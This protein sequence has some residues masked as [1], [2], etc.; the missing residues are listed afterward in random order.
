MFLRY[1]GRRTT[2]LIAVGK[3]L[4]VLAL[5]R[6]KRFCEYY[7]A[8]GL[9]ETEKCMWKVSILESWIENRLWNHADMNER[10]L[11]WLETS[12]RMAFFRPEVAFRIKMFQFDGLAIIF[13]FFI[14]SFSHFLIFHITEYIIRSHEVKPEGYEEAHDGKCITVFSAPNYWLVV[15]IARSKKIKKR[16]STCLAASD[17]TRK[18]PCRLPSCADSCSSFP[19][20]FFF[21]HVFSVLP[22]L[23]LSC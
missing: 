5:P 2:L 3:S 22:A 18:I 1:L 19:F 11:T 13:F 20:T 7:W 12:V 23:F 6:S 15:C 8:T 4:S 16:K 17:S 9:V 14:C 21:L 10:I